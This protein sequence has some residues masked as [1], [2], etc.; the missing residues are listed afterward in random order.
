MVDS[1]LDETSYFFADDDGLEVEH[2]HLLH[3]LRRDPEGSIQG[4]VSNWT[5]VRANFFP[6]DMSRRKMRDGH[7]PKVLKLEL[8]VRQIVLCDTLKTITVS[9]RRKEFKQSK[10]CGHLWI[11]RWLEALQ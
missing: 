6:Y 4:F 7:K 8:D 10:A 2:G 1:G 9:L 11:T 3:G 5:L